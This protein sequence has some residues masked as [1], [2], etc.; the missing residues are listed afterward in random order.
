MTL[1]GHMMETDQPVCTLIYLDVSFGSQ[2]QTLVKDSKNSRFC[3][4]KS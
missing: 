4:Q 1:N 3:P 2:D